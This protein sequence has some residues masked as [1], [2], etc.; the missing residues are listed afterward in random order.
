MRI[1]ELKAKDREEKLKLLN[2]S[3]RESFNYW[4]LKEETANTEREE[5]REES[6]KALL[7]EMEALQTA[8]RKKQHQLFGQEITVNGWIFEDS[9]DGEDDD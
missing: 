1:L 5:E 4:A 8:A 9:T 7:D 6:L 3:E 2:E